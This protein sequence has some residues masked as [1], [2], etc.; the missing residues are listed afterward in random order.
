MRGDKT[1]RHNLLRNE[2]FYFCKNANLNPELESPGLLQPRPI[3]GSTQEDGVARDDT[4]NRRPADIY[5]P[6]WRR[7]G[8]AALDF[9]VTSVLRSDIVRR[10]AVDGS[11]AVSAYEDVKRSH[12]DTAASCQTEGLTFIPV[13][14]E[15]DGEDW[16]PAAQKT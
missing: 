12:L 8:P 3:S 14:C 4:R 1:K 13:V 5:L 10:L 2:V 11:S 15:A 6:R 7:G 16:G 9:A